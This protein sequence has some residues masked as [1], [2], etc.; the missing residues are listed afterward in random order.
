MCIQ[1]EEEEQQS[2]RGNFEYEAASL[3]LKKDAS[4]GDSNNVP[5]V[6]HKFSAVNCH[7]LPCNCS[8]CYHS[9]QNCVDTSTTSPFRYQN[10]NEVDN[11]GSRTFTCLD[12]LL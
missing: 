10:G 6:N 2:P 7:L 5:N 8:L 1:I 9:K 12:G 11:I 3:V 4:A